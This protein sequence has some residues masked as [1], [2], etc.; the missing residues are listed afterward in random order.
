M[1]Q[2]KDMEKERFIQAGTYVDPALEKERI[3]KEA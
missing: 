1:I 2:K 3:R